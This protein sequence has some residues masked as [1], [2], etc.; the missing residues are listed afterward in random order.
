[1]SWASNREAT[2]GEDRAY[3]LMGIFG[4]QMPMLY[5]ARDDNAFLR[6][7]LE[8]LRVSDDE[9][10]FAWFRPLYEGHA[11]LLVGSLSLFAQSRDII[12]ATWDHRRPP[13]SMTNKG[14]R[15]ELVLIPDR[16]PKNGPPLFIPPLNCARSVR[17]EEKEDPIEEEDTTH[18]SRKA[19]GFL[20][21]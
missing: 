21:I 16:S 6:L 8:I 11:G 17:R 15:T 20:A 13:Y 2:R 12:R 18:R 10:I 4:V 7:Q 3:S 1:M 19:D 5:G 14:L 9:P